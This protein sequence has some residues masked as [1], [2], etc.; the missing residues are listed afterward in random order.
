[1][2]ECIECKNSTRAYKTLLMRVNGTHACT[3]V[4]KNGHRVNQ[5]LSVSKTYVRRD[6]RERNSLV[7][8]VN[9]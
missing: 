8:R 9:L 2:C 3:H 7:A 1:M 6:H 5:R 4:N